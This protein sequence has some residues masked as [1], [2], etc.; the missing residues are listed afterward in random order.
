MNKIFGA[1]TAF[2]VLAAMLAP[3]S[4][5]DRDDARHATVT[6]AGTV[7]SI[8]REGFALDTGNAVQ[9]IE[10]ER[11]T[12]FTRD[13]QPASFADLAVGQRVSVQGRFERTE[14]EA[15]SVAIRS[16]VTLSGAIESIGPG[17][18]TVAGKSVVVGPATTITAGGLAV[19]LAD[20]RVGEQATVT[21]QVQAD[22]S[23]LAASV[24][25]PSGVT[26][27]GVIDSLAAPMLVV[28]GTTVTSSAATLISVA[29][30]PAGFADLAVG[31]SV[32]VTGVVQADGSILA[33]TI[34]AP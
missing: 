3:A 7:T 18:L 8:G 31:D 29:G 25:V 1:G 28:S 2:L 23:V 16:I 9:P 32:V 6:L 14:F 13:G 27:S 34:A 5:R 11:S 21:G 33:Q 30:A 26:L 17:G 10:V 22:G 20:L 24:T 19:G 4:A 15:G 12:V